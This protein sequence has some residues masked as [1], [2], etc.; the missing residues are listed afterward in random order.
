MAVDDRNGDG[1]RFQRSPTGPWVAPPP[2]APA[3]PPQP[4]RPSGPPLIARR[5]SMWSVAVFV[6]LLAGYGIRAYRDLSSP[7]AWAY[8]KDQ[9]FSPSLSATLVPNADIDSSGHRRAALAIHGAIG[10]AGASWLRT[11]IDEAHLAPG[12]AILLSSP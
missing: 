12:D 10:A 5:R 4:P 7:D 9:Y 3:H 11:Q 6:L 2:R 1:Q 8:W